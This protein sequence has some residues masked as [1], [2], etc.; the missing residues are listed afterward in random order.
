[1]T[2]TLRRWSPVAAV[3]VLLGV[4]KAESIADPNV[5]WGIR[6]GRTILSSGHLPHSDAWSW[7]VRGKPWVPN[8]WGWDVVL[9]GL[10]RLGGGAG[11]A[12]LNIAVVLVLAY[13]IARRAF[14]V[15]APTV[16]VAATLAV[17]GG[18]TLL[19]WIN[20][21]PQLISYV[22]VAVIVPAVAPG[23]RASR[24]RF[25]SLLVVLFVLQIVWV[26]L[27]FFAIAGPVLVGVAGS[28]ALLT[29]RT[30]VA[31]SGVSA[32]EQALRT[33]VA[34]AVAFGGCCITPYG[35]VVAAKTVAVR[36]DAAGLIV[37]WRP[38]GFATFSQITGL[39]AILAAIG[40]GVHAYRARRLDITAVL[41]VLAIGTALACRMAPVTTVVAIPEL[42]AA[43]SA[44]AVRRSRIIVAVT[45]MFG[46][47][48]LGI[49]AA[50]AGNLGKL[51]PASTSHDLVEQ[52]PAGC[53]LLNDYS[54]GGSVILFRPDVPVAID[55]R[56][57]LFGKQRILANRAL[58]AG[59]DDAMRAVDAQGITCVLIPSGSGLVALLDRDRRWQVVGTD[60][61]RTLL[62]RR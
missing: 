33:V 36:N 31:S 61:R 46:L 3:A 41:V 20:D 17:A 57:D 13:L 27:H 16:G 52:L 8:S 12:A 48:G 23:L 24:R 11:L 28:G 6:D 56:T 35:A 49:A 4:V 59:R 26:N 18:A 38:A 1:M 15:G 58:V 29:R 50:D 54:L 14:E 34:V 47:V 39:L 5:L 60:D 25:V 9:G 30:T 62:V 19:P 32:R 22:F 7:T 43:C 51:D 42:A 55:S 53:R 37:E 44:L 21:R 10:D 45:A 40:A 2:T